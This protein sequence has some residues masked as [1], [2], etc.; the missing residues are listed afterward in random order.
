MDNVNQ[1]RSDT[2]SVINAPVSFEHDGKSYLLSA[3]T[4][5][6]L[7]EVRDHLRAGVLASTEKLLATVESKE[8][9]DFY[10]AKAV[11]EVE[12]IEINSPRYNHLV[13]SDPDAT[14]YFFWVLL[15]K[16]HPELGRADVERLLIEKGMKAKG[17]LEAQ[18]KAK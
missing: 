14:I 13:Q 7:K 10:F 11:K 17:E 1:L 16:K 3:P 12:E 4:L 2:A 9:R 5:A 8:L 15:R 18:L 6:D